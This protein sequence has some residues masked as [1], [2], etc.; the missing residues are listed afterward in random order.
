[1]FYSLI[2]TPAG[3][4]LLS[5]LFISLVTDLWR[6]KVYNALTFPTLLILLILRVLDGGIYGFLY[7]FLAV[8]LVFLF[9]LLP[10]ALQYMGGGDIKLFML[11]AAYFKYPLLLKVLLSIFI[12]GG[13]LAL[14]SLLGVPY[15][16]YLIHS[17]GWKPRFL[18]M[19]AHKKI[20]YA[21]AV[22]MG[23]IVGS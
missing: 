20:P 16:T 1:M 12:W 13:G 9:F 8:F 17:F 3:I 21:V 10:Y 14:I 4:L 11:V 18:R 2:S 23:V 22:F 15:L 5:V 6:G 7:A 19:L